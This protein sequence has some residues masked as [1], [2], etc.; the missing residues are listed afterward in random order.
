M[1]S[2]GERQRVGMARALY[3]SPELLIFDDNFTALDANL[4]KEIIAALSKWKKDRIT[5]VVSSYPEV[6]E[7]ADR[8]IDL[9]GREVAGNG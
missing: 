5:V 6:L 7:K 3:G 9:D 8:V 1:L 4:R 2:G